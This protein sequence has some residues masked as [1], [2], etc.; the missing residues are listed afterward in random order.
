MKLDLGCGRRCKE[1]FTGVDISPE[2]GAEIVH[3]LS[4][5]PWPFEDDSVEEVNCS[6]FLEHL[7]GDE[8]MA[9]MDELYRVLKPG[10]TATIT[11][12]YWTWVGAV[13]DPTHRWPPIAEQSYYYFNR[14]MRERMGVDHYPIRCNFDYSLTCVAMPHLHGRSQAEMA[15][16]H[17]H[18]LN[19]VTELVATLVKR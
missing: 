13:Q 12:P 16:A 7:D 19:A 2:C 18:Q 5:M 10:G 8:R 14:E 9:F 15:H 3:D 4:E 1:G 17:Y 6:H 11:T